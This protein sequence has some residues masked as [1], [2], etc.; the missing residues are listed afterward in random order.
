MPH[1]ESHV[2]RC[3]ILLLC[4]GICHLSRFAERSQKSRK[5]KHYNSSRCE[6]GPPV[7]N[8]TSFEYSATISFLFSGLTKA[9]TRVVSSPILAF[10]SL[11]SSALFCCLLACLCS[12]ALKLDLLVADKILFS[13]CSRLAWSGI[14]LVNFCLRAL[15]ASVSV[16]TSVLFLLLDHELEEVLFCSFADLSQVSVE[17]LFLS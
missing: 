1:G 9:F 4:N 6:L 16:L 14:G 5:E 15:M 10:K 13:A 7:V 17:V 12:E 3:Q 11:M 2:S 8:H